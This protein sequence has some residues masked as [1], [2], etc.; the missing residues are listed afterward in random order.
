[1]T[2][3]VHNYA[4]EIDANFTD[5]KIPHRISPWIKK[6]L[7]KRCYYLG[8]FIWLLW[9]RLTGKYNPLEWYYN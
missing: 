5:L 8:T 4:R 6:L 3:G 7:R 1:M 2:H 9:I